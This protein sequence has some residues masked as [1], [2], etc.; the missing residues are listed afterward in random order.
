[1]KKKIK[2]S[3]APYGSYLFNVLLKC[4]KTVFSVLIWLRCW[5]DSPK[6]ISADPPESNIYKR[7]HC[8]ILFNRGDIQTK[9][10]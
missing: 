6:F 10:L 5:I 2:F 9:R 4:Q 7:L 3:V 8:Y 1:M